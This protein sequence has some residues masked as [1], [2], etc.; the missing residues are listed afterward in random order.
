METTVVDRT[1]VLALAEKDHGSAPE[2]T[3]VN[4]RINVL[5][6]SGRADAA[7]RL[8]EQVTGWSATAPA[9]ATTAPAAGAAATAV[10]PTL[11][12]YLPIVRSVPE[13]YRDV[14]QAAD[15][16]LA[17]FHD[18]QARHQLRPDAHLYS[19]VIAA[20]T[21]ADRADDAYRLYLMMRADR[22]MPSSRVFENLFR[23]LGRA[24]DLARVDAL[25]ADL[26]A[27]GIRP[28][29]QLSH[30]L[31]KVCRMEPFAVVLGAT[32]LDRVADV[33]SG[34]AAATPPARRVFAPRGSATAADRHGGAG[35][36]SGGTEGTGL[37]P[38]LERLGLAQ[39]GRGSAATRRLPFPGIDDYVATASSTLAPLP[40]TLTAEDEDGASSTSTS[41]YNIGSAHGRLEGL[42]A[43]LFASLVPGRRASSA[44]PPPT[45]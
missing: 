44:R 10:A 8:F 25:Y 11:L 14:Q 45:V 28:S 15:V 21:D 43:R 31:I 27:T 35:S 1:Q 36:D 39:H 23:C 33:K 17:L 2:I 19:T 24:N 42:V 34:L 18:A 9:S 40:T 12:T 22:I 30:V 4:M 3:L 5:L 6:A 26:V 20:L 16:S 37:R 7:W 13:R 29:R 41:S 38:R 32:E